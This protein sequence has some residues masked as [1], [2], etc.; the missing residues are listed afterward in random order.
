M[1]IPEIDSTSSLI[2][3]EYMTSEHGFCVRADYQT[4]GRGQ[5][6]NRWESEAG[7]N[8]LFS[9]LLHPELPIAQAWDINIAVALAIVEAIHETCPALEGLSIKWP[10]DIYIG[11]SKV[12]GTLIENFVS[13][14]QIASS[15]VGIGLN[16]NQRLF[17][18]DAPNPISLATA[19]TQQGMPSELE[20]EPLYERIVAHILHPSYNREQYMAMLYR[21]DGRL[22]RWETEGKEF[23]ASIAGI[24]D[25]G[26]LILQQK[27]GR[28]QAFR[29][30]EV[31]HVL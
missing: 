20:I 24:S 30:K 26:E 5:Q 2:R 16:V 25:F 19:L 11:D 9:M 15:I 29:L 3:R 23:M 28:Q 21:N 14:N 12:C 6:G 8:L 4:G 18:S 13:G 31:K 22:Y 7:Q 1:H 17:V 27:N 10:N